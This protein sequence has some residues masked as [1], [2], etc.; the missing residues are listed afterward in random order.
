M[1]AS[2]SQ[3][4]PLPRSA[5]AEIAERPLRWLIFLTVAGAPLIYKPT[6]SAFTESLIWPKTAWVM[7][8]C[9]LLV[10]LALRGRD[11]ALWKPMP[12][13][14]GAIAIALGATSMIALLCG[15]DPLLA[16][17]RTLRPYLAVGVL[18]AFAAM[19]PSARRAAIAAV[20]AGGS[21][22]AITVLLQEWDV[23]LPGTGIDIPTNFLLPAGPNTVRNAAAL[24]LMP[25][26]P[27]AYCRFAASSDRRWLVVYGVSICL[28]ISALVA[29]RARVSLAAAMLAMTAVLARVPAARRLSPRLGLLVVALIAT[30]SMRAKS[31]A[32]QQTDFIVEK[33]THT[34]TAADRSHR[35]RLEI[36][37][38][39][40]E[41][42]AEHPL[43]GTGGEQFLTQ[44]AAHNPHNAT[45]GA[46]AHSQWLQLAVD[47][48]L[49][50]CV[51]WL[52]A[53]LLCAAACVR[54]LLR[55]GPDDVAVAA[56]TLALLAASVFEPVLMVPA[57][58]QN[59]G[60]LA[61]VSVGAAEER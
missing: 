8:G 29:T 40:A 55:H 36:W 30:L 44:W 1:I 47:F 49:P 13:G 24:A 56:A 17:L 33:V 12:R 27:L 20:I 25:A 10:A 35:E 52:C 26:L 59:V 28:L 60:V 14:W 18:F 57:V 3:I 11:R 5:A 37:T 45:V 4:G 9:L 16:G 42:I 7:T 31:P 32:H 41:L 43:V 19:A 50:A 2:T 15:P 23:W 58:Y 54:L 48:G 53:A 6:H 39:A 61:G 34:L 21:V 46:H 22:L 51:L 38:L